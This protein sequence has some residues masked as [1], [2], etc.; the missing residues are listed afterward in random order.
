[1]IRMLA[2][3]EF[4]NLLAKFAYPGQKRLLEE[5]VDNTGSDT[6]PMLVGGSM[7]CNLLGADNLTT[8]IDAPINFHVHGTLSQFVSRPN[9]LLV[10]LHNIHTEYS[11]PVLTELSSSAEQPSSYTPLLLN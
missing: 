11:F 8:M 9:P 10:S 5:Y 7:H 1:M 4:R 6:A 3:L 2:K